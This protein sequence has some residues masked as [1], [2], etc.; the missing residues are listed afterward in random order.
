[1]IHLVCKVCYHINHEIYGCNIFTTAIQ[2]TLRKSCEGN[3]DGLHLL[4]H[5]NSNAT[6]SG[7]LHPSQAGK[8]F[9]VASGPGLR[10]VYCSFFTSTGD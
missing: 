6:Y 5:L 4:E 7:E 3:E 10:F 1:M 2:Y 9:K 8:P